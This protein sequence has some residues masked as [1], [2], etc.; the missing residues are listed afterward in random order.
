[1]LVVRILG[2][3]IHNLEA[4]SLEAGS[5]GTDSQSFEAGI[6]MGVGVLPLLALFY[7]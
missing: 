5:L 3:D 1:M 4:G 6:Q 2:G 7:T